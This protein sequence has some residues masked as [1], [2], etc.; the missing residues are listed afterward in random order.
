MKS[1]HTN[2]NKFFV[3]VVIALEIYDPWSKQTRKIS[4]SLKN[5]FSIYFAICVKK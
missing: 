5:G 4:F 2:F 3:Y 1:L